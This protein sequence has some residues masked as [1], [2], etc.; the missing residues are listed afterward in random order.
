MRKEGELQAE[1]IGKLPDALA[2][3]DSLIEQDREGLKKNRH[4]GG[5]EVAAVLSANH[6][7]VAGFDGLQRA[8]AKHFLFGQGRLQREAD[9]AA[10]TACEKLWS[11]P[12]TTTKAVRQTRQ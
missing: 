1:V 5:G 9:S 10:G 7:D 12:S 8:F 6:F 3:G 4:V 11:R 2:V